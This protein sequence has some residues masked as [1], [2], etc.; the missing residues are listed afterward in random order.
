MKHFSWKRGLALLLILCLLSAFA[1]AVA[2][3]APAVTPKEPT[4]QFMTEPKDAVTFNWFAGNYCTF[5]DT[6]ANCAGICDCFG[7]VTMTGKNIDLEPLENGMAKEMGKND[8]GYYGWAVLSPDGKPLTPY[9]SGGEIACAKDRYTGKVY[10]WV[11]GEFGDGERRIDVNGNDPFAGKYDSCTSIWNG[12]FAYSKNGKWGIDAM[13]GSHILPCI[14]EELDFCDTDRCI[15]AENG[16]YGIIDL[17]GNV[18]VAPAYDMLWRDETDTGYYAIQDDK[19]GAITNELKQT[20]PCIYESAGCFSEN[21]SYGWNHDIGRLV[22]YD[23]EGNVKSDVTG[24]YFWYSSIDRVF[25]YS[26]E[27]SDGTGTYTVFNAAG[28]AII[29]GKRSKVGVVSNDMILFENNGN[30][31]VYDE[32]GT[33]LNTIENAMPEISQDRIPTVHRD[34]MYAI[35]GTDAKLSTDFVY[36]AEYYSHVCKDNI[37]CLQRDGRWYLV[38]R[39]GKEYPEGGMDRKVDFSEDSE[40]AGYT[41]NGYSGI[42][43]YVGADESRFT[44]VAK[45]AWYREAADFCADNGLMVG[46][47]TGVFS[48][49]V[50]TTRSMIVSLLY[51]L[52]GAEKPTGENPFTDVP[53]GK[54]YTD[55]VMWAAENEVVAGYGDGKFGPN[56]PIT[57]E[58]IAVIFCNYARFAKLDTSQTKPLDSFPDAGKVNAW[59]K[60]AV[61]WAVAEGLIS[62]SVIG[63]QAVLD[64]QGT[65]TRAMAASILMRFIQNCR[66]AEPTDPGDVVLP[67]DEFDN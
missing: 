63:G 27:N 22:L 14:Y 35:V 8:Q 3:E 11:S 39:S 20:V 52:S 67:P 41:V 19:W 21:V 49:D 38:T 64:P 13:D 50:T 17:S 46:T 60:N 31:D 7:N 66:P 12:K 37:A 44:D 40:Y 36:S 6:G 26:I 10:N 53:D 33:L 51:R 65:A 16:K 42:L 4:I 29:D 15:F 54:W 48:P 24:A 58:Q 59:A 43:R 2:A 18:L 62:G 32:N 23:A 57:R 9:T 5:Y 55:A 28:E 61:C 25:M 56:D 1:P 45:D 47:A 30:T 34:G